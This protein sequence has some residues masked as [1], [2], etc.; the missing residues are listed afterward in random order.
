MKIHVKI[1]IVVYIYMKMGS[2]EKNY[3]HEGAKVKEE[4]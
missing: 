4:K 2:E 3:L 1:I